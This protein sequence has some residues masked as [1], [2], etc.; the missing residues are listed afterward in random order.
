MPCFP[1][2]FMDIYLLGIGWQHTENT[3]IE[4]RGQIPP[5]YLSSLFSPPPPTTIFVNFSDVIFLSFQNTTL[6]KVVSQ[7]IYIG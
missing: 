4:R 1:F 7:N 3:T 6:Y 5:K 2:H